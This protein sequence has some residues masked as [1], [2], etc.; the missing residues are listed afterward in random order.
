MP[1]NKSPHEGHRARMRKRLADTSP[2]AFAEHEILEMLLYYTIARGD[3]NETAHSLLEAFGSIEGVLDADAARLKTVWGIGESAATFLTLVGEAARRYATEKFT[4]KQGPV[5]ALD[6]PEKIVT[7]L[8]PRFMGASKEI[9][10]VLLLDNAMRPVDCFPLASGTVSAVS[11]SV[12]AIAERTYSKQAAA[13]ILAHNHPGG[14]AAPSGDDVKLTH[15][16]KEALSL[17]EIPLVEHY[18]FSD[19][20]YAPILNQFR[21]DEEGAFAASSLFDLIKTNIHKKENKQK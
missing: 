6:T 21:K 4:A 18:V 11:V 2:A 8:A 20:A 12:R 3:T 15:H 1:T 17:L 13:V 5:R 19:N 10:L 9:L 7:F 14:I 16:I